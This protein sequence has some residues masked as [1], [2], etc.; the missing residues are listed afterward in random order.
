MIVGAG[1]AGSVAALTLARRGHRVLL[2]DRGRLDLPRVGETAPPELAAVLADLDLAHVLA[3]HR[4]RASPAVAS[5][6]GTDTP[7]ERHHIL[8][9]YGSGW[10]L[11]RM[12]FDA[13]LATAARDAGADLRLGTQVGLSFDDN[14][15][16]LQSSRGS[17][18]RSRR[19]ILATGRSG[20]AMG[21]QCRR[22]WI[23]R[24]VA[25]SALTPPGSSCSEPRTLIES[26]RE[27]WVY[28][29]LLP[30]DQ[31]IIV[32]MTDSRLVPAGRSA[33][34][35]WWQDVVGRSVLLRG[36]VRVAAALELSTHDARSSF[37]LPHSGHS[38]LPAGDARFAIDP[39]AGQ[40]IVRAIEDGLWAAQRLVQDA[41]CDTCSAVRERTM[42]EL[43]MYLKTRDAYYSMEQRWP[44]APFWKCYRALDT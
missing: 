17:I 44:E 14:H 7:S 4:H 30:A 42:S 15:Y 13:S 33:R 2:V 5:A 32:L 39:L 1:P 28:S 36:L 38:W 31:R 10:H 37:L 12:S 6:W 34:V 43:A 20:G 41:N 18:G 22:V 26:V 3:E 19:L 11:D 25:V 27:G 29:A 21:L 9:P 8:S 35:R 23:D 24:L 40:G 16:Q